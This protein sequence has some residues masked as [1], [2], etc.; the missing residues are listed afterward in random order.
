MRA[1]CLLVMWIIWKHRNDIVFNGA[2]LSIQAVL[3]SIM[4][5]GHNW[6]AAGLLRID[7]SLPTRVDSV[8]SSE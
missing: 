1:K 6:R 4:S 8:D 2:T 3:D 7:G 5:E